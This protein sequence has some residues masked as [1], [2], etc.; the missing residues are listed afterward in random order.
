MPQIDGFFSL[1]P[2]EISRVTALPYDHPDRGFPRLLDFLGVSQTTVPGKT[3]EW[4]SRPSAMPLVTAGQQPV[5]ADDR[6][7]FDALTQ[8][9]LDLRRIVFLPTAARGSI[10]ATQQTAARVRET[11]FANQNISLQTEAPAESMV[12]ISQTYYPAW[13][14][15]VDGL[16]AKIWRANYAFQALQVPAG[17][18]QVQLHYEDKNLHRGAVLSGLGLLL[19]VGL[20]VV[21]HFRRVDVSTSTALSFASCSRRN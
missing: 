6:A 12:V 8:P 21:A 13:R 10:S 19:S 14:A 15:Y 3:L 7:T 16:P 18:H 11:K 17:H 4:A 1:T 2:R 9:N 5:F 20:W